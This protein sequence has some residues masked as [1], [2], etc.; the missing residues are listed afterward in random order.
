MTW[1]CSRNKITTCAHTWKCCG[2]TFVSQGYLAATYPL[3]WQTPILG[4]F[5][6]RDV[7]HEVQ[8][9]GTRRCNISLGHVPANVFMCVHKWFSSLLHMSPLHVPNACRFSVYYTPFCRCKIT[10]QHD[11]SILPTLNIN[12]FV[13]FNMHLNFFKVPLWSKKPLPFFLQILK[14][15]LLNTWL[16][17][18]WALTF[19]QRPFTLRVI[20][21]FHCPPLLT[22]KTDRLDLRRLDPGKSDVRGSLA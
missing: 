14:V 18:F 9:P 17:K 11:P 5:C 13:L 1:T 20:F 8:L 4:W 22:F 2:Y 12:I 21:G 7:S 6:S 3:V 10:L 16:A 19:I 15:C